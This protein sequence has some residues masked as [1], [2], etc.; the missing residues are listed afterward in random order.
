M[1]IETMAMPEIRLDEVLVKVEACNV[2]Q[3]LKNILKGMDGESDFAFP[4]LPAVFGL[5]VAGVVTEVGELT[6]GFSKGDRVYVNPGLSCGGCEACRA[7]RSI[8]CEGFALR[9]Y[10]GIGPALHSQ[11]SLDDRPQGG[12]AQFMSVPQRNLVRIPDNLDFDTASR[13]GYLGTAYRALKLAECGPGK[14]VLISGVTGTLGLGAPALAIAMGAKKVLGIARNEKLFAGVEGLAEPGRIKVLKSGNQDLKE[15]SRRATD[16]D[17][18][19]I[20]I[21]ALSGDAPAEALTEPLA[22]LK[23][24][25]CLVNIGAVQGEVP[26]DLF[27]ALSNNIRI[28]GSSWFTT[29]EAQEMADLVEQGALDLSFYEHEKFPL[30]EVNAAIDGTGDRKGGFTNT[31]VNPN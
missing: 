19:D 29:G 28:I 22:C 31:V 26:I 5:D 25:G 6:R 8:D 10:F 4:V 12:F 18:V 27:W 17:G 13:F 2:V 21:D 23:R 30:D 11:R 16:G 7:E 14:V 15:W 20:V 24:G 9:G 3:N 1:K